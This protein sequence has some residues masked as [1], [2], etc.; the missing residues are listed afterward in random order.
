M[1]LSHQQYL[2]VYG[3]DVSRAVANLE[4]H[5]IRLE[6]RSESSAGHL[7]RI[8]QAGGKYDVWIDPSHWITSNWEDFSAVEWVIM[9]DLIEAFILLDSIA[10]VSST[11]NQA[12]R[13]FD[14]AT[15][16][17]AG[18]LADHTDRLVELF[19]FLV[20]IENAPSHP[21][22]NVLEE[23]MRD[24]YDSVQVRQFQDEQDGESVLLDEIHALSAPTSS[25]RANKRGARSVKMGALPVGFRFASWLLDFRSWIFC[26]AVIALRAQVGATESGREF[27]KFLQHFCN[28]RE[29]QSLPE[30]AHVLNAKASGL[31]FSKSTD[32]KS[33]AYAYAKRAVSLAPT[34]P[35]SNHSAA[36]LVL[37]LAQTS[38]RRTVSLQDGLIYVDVAIE[39]FPDYPKNFITRG[40]IH[41]HMDRLREASDDCDRAIYLIG[42]LFDDD[43]AEGEDGLEQAYSLRSAIDAREIELE[44]L[45]RFL[46]QAEL[47]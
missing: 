25:I 32:A 39:N 31:G 44:R 45:S 20:A 8:R 17:L 22:A 38:R 26:A 7:R 4:E 34:W 13:L 14:S 47:P 11:E 43:D 33:Q 18:A 30:Y 42:R 9:R 36:R 40:Q 21:A 27:E 37:E 19:M 23:T 3:A 29:V 24:C 28:R 41:L 35:N 15:Y 1:T 10:P 12:L 2:M 16:H 46:S 5:L 6:S